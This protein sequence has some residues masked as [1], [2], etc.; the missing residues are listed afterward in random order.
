MKTNLQPEHPLPSRW[1]HRIAIAL[2]A[3]VF[4]LIWVGGLVTTYDAGMAVPDWPGTYGYNMFLYPVETWITGPF[5]LLVEH[6]HRL[7]GSLS[8]FIAIALVIVT[9]KTETR[10]SVRWFSVAL[11]LL[12]IGQGVLGGLRVLLDARTL[13]KIH[14]CVGPAFLA[15]VVGFCVVTSRWWWRQALPK[16]TVANLRSSGITNLAL[17]MLVVSFGQLI[18][19]AFLRHVAVTAAP[20]QYR[21]LILLHIATAILI[22]AGTFVQWFRSRQ[23]RYRSSGIRGSINVLFLLVSVQFLLGFGTW[24][25]KFGWPV[26]FEN[27]RFAATFVVGEKTFLQMNLITAHQAT[28]SL[29]LAFWTIHLLRCLRAIGL[30]SSSLKQTPISAGSNQAS[31][32]TAEPANTLIAN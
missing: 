27:M 19:G 1:P 26:W 32:S 14:G 13:A 24:V 23:S 12:V 7:L 15:A 2:A 18:V 9:W 16:K 3:V 4:P 22:V 25:V 21:I 10:R 8:G 20:S 17:L 29:I 31:P 5:D 28:G 6:G 30:R 11:L